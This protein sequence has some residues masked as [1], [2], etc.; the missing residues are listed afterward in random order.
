MDR[1]G[2]F[3]MRDAEPDVAEGWE[4]DT[5]GRWERNIYSYPPIGSPDGGAHCTAAD[6]VGFLRAVRAGT[7]LPPELTDAFLTPQVLHDGTEDDGVHYGFGPSFVVADGQ[8]RSLFKEG[9]NTGASAFVAHR[10][11]HDLDFAIVAST[12]SGA[13]APLK[14]IN[15]RLAEAV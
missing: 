2:F 15:R 14:E 8:V 7:L 10:P 3:D 1:S 4:R 5:D 11:A 12:E 13:W 9:V 6:L